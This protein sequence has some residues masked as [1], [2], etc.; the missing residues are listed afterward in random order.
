MWN[1]VSE[2]VESASAISIGAGGDPEKLVANFLTR[3]SLEGLFSSL[4]EASLA[5]NENQVKLV[6]KAL[7]FV[8]RSETFRDKL[9]HPEFLPFLVSGF[10]HREVHIRELSV[11]HI[12]EVGIGNFPE[13][14]AETI[15]EEII[16]A[17]T[18]P[19]TSVALCATNV[20]L[21]YSEEDQRLETVLDTLSKFV[22]KLKEG[23]CVGDP[24]TA[25]LRIFHIIATLSAKG[26]DQLNLCKSSGA[27]NPLLDL[28]G[29]DDVLLQLNALNL[30]PL[31]AV[32]DPGFDLLIQSNVV[33]RLS[34]MAGLDKSGSEPSPF[35]GDY[36]LKVMSQLSARA[37]GPSPT[38]EAGC[39]QLASM[40]LDIVS[41]RVNRCIETRD[42][43]E[44]ATLLLALGFFAGAQPP[45]SMREILKPEL[46]KLV[47]TWMQLANLT[48]EKF[49]IA[50]LESLAKALRGGSVVSNESQYSGSDELD[51]LEA[52]M[53]VKMYGNITRNQRQEAAELGR[54]L[55]VQY[56]KAFAQQRSKTGNSDTIGILLDLIKV[57]IDDIRCAAFSVVR[58]IAGQD[59]EWGLRS[60]FAHP[61]TTSILFDRSLEMSKP[62]KEWRFSV[63]EAINANPQNSILED[64]TLEK[65]MRFLRQGPFRGPSNQAGTATTAIEMEV[66]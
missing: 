11:K 18:D 35:L 29:S 17:L 48:G 47:L 3:N 66:A 32:T 60:L 23:S 58:M 27:L 26:E 63:I 54:E 36:S 55:V 33:Q 12:S 57:P 5:D 56:G 16:Q 28:V 59:A 24:S 20:I 22:L 34:E 46:D 4:E 6:A 53:S 15:F 40:F 19:D 8:F 7:D 10:Q 2:F 41:L 44:A 21:K 39:N 14:S 30:I 64:P 1:A 9:T 25:L 65:V 45:E 49:Q 52:K 38:T 37:L 51:K 42:A 31:V 50:G 13:T 61:N 62:A 43:T